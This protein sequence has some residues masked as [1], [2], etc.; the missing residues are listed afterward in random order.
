MFKKQTLIAL[1]LFFVGALI[2]AGCQKAT[3]LDQSQSQNQK[4]PQASAM[5]TQQEQKIQQSSG[6]MTIN[7]SYPELSGVADEAVMTNVNDDL[8]N[9]ADG[10]VAN[11]EK[12]VAD[13]STPL[14]GAKSTLDVSYA[15][16]DLSAKIAS[17]EFSSSAYVEGSAHPNNEVHG[18]N[19]NLENG[20]MIGLADVFDENTNY[21]PAL[22]KTAIQDLKTQAQPN[23]LFDNDMLS[24]ALA[25]KNENFSDFAITN[26]DLVFFPAP[27]SVAPA[28]SGPQTI[29]I[30]F[31]EM[32]SYFSPDFK[33]LIDE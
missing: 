27:Y 33:Q 1:P 6:K 5:P 19:Y 20:K 31:S 12:S 14:P 22:S 8:K 13:N 16:Q 15:V 29:K 24:Q 7:V 10:L 11:F 4:S 18:L 26:T 30:G 21:L 28:V 17:F 2:L 25:P 9:Y 23:S 3:S 32:E